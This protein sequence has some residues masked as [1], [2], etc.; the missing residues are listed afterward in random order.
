MK[1]DRT[2]RTRSSR[3]LHGEPAFVKPYGYY[4]PCLS[5]LMGSE[6]EGRGFKYRGRNSKF[7][8]AKKLNDIFK[9]LK[10]ACP[11]VGRMVSQVVVYRF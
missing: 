9:G 11:A 6:A 1:Q 4:F 8:Y 3:S 10:H 7:T 5:I 2:R